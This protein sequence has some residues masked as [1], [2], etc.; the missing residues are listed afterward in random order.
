MLESLCLPPVVVGA[1][2]WHDIRWDGEGQDE[3]LGGRIRAK[4]PLN[5]YLGGS[6]VRAELDRRAV[7]RR[8]RD[9][10]KEFINH[11]LSPRAA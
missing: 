1:V 6:A 9:K 11:E 10:F 7:M 3:V 5:L 4:L 2:R 8:A